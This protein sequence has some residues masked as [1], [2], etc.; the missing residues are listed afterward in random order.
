MHSQTDDLVS[1]QATVG[2]TPSGMRSFFAM[3]SAS[4]SKALIEPPSAA[5]RLVLDAVGFVIDELRSNKALQ[6]DPWV[7]QLGP[8]GREAFWGILSVVYMYLLGDTLHRTTG[9]TA[10]TAKNAVPFLIK[11]GPWDLVRMAGT[12]KMRSN[13]PPPELARGIGHH[14]KQTRFL[15][16]SYWTDK[17]GGAV[18]EG[19]LAK[20][21][22]A[23]TPKTELVAGDYVDVVESML[24]GDTG[25]VDVLQ[26]GKQLPGMDKLTLDSGGVNVERESFRQAGIPLEYR[27]IKKY[28]SHEIFDA[29][30]AIVQHVRDANMRDLNNEQRAKVIAA[31]QQR[32]P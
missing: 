3:A 24:C 30:A 13:P 6:A 12:S 21:V 4:D 26:S 10:S 28:R 19:L 17:S 2:V 18:G 1:L 27:W 25:L 9:G 22:R 29:M 32:Q 14:F 8:A 15:K 31:F 16:V 20:R 7:K 5:R 23:R 11:S